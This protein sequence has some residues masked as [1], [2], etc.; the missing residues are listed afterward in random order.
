MPLLEISV[1]PVGTGSPSFSSHVAQ[2]VRLVEERGLDYQVTPTATVIEGDLGELLQVARDIH[3]QS[4]INGVDRVI[5][6]LS[7]DDRKDKPQ[8]LSEPVRSV[9]WSVEG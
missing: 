2:A 1:V 9:Q 6:S 8:T 5:T 3:E 7:I 4:F